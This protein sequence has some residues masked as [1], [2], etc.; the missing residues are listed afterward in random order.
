MIDGIERSFLIDVPA[1]LKPGASLVMVFHGYGGS[2]GGIRK[3]A[4]FTPLVE[5]Y[6]FIAVYPMGS[7]DK[8][9]KRFFNVGYK[10]H[11][12]MKIDD[13]KFARELAAKL[14]NELEL[15]PHSIFST[16]MSNGADMSY[17]LAC[18]PKPLVKAIAPVAGCM[19]STWVKDFTI[20]K[21]TPVMEVH[22][23]RDKVTLWEGDPKNRY[24]W[25]AYLGTDA[26]MNFWVRTLSLEK[27]DVSELPD[28]QSRK[29]T[30]G[31][32][33]HRW[34]TTEDNMEVRLY[35]IK[36]GGH[37]WPDY[38]GNREISTANEIWNFFQRHRPQYPENL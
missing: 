25:G 21:R 8:K 29:K 37:S 17:L 22:G 14:I 2:A 33:L 7:E 31:L 26:V 20:E 24:G 15:D 32:S 4:G 12:S 19:M 1:H 9:G 34:W 35:K 23:T 36:G 10:F 16:G 38:L 6:G 18:Q 13:V 5:Q 27:S 11:K 30:L 28:I 3:Y